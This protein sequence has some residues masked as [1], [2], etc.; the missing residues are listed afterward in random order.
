MSLPAPSADLA[1]V[2]KALKGKSTRIT[3]RDQ[4]D[5]VVEAEDTEESSA[6]QNHIDKEAF[7]RL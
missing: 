4:S 2:A 6:Q 7:L 1:W 3:A 5:K